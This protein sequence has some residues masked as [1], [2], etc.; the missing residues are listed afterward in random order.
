MLTISKVPKNEEQFFASHKHDQKKK[1]IPSILGNTFLKNQKKKLAK[2]TGFFIL[3]KSIYV[4]YTKTG[5][6]YL[7]VV[8]KDGCDELVC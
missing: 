3:I 4:V 8:S 2:I 5:D 6:V 1:C 7:Y